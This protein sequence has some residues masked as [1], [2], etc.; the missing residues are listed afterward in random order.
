MLE[1]VDERFMKIALK[2]AEKAAEE[3]EVPVGA[4]IVIAG[5]VI[6]CSH[7]KKEQT[8]DPTA[9]AE[10]LAIRKA[11]EKIGNWRLEGATLYVTKEPCPM[12]AGALVNA[13]INRVVYGCKDKKAGAVDSLF[14]IPKDKR[15]NHTL[16]VT[17]G[18][19]EEESKALLRKFFIE[20]RR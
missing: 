12:C 8:N 3:D 14:N 2:E 9:H 18:V 17:S 5:K 15:L 19:F 20:K 1:N 7:N 4:V 6:A 10:I 13:R 11:S 16:K